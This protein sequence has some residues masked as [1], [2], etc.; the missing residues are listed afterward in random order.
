MMRYSSVAIALAAALI[1]VAGCSSQ[2]NVEQVAVA[3]ESGTNHQ[4]NS[5]SALSAA[6]IAPLAPSAVPGRGDALL[7]P[8]GANQA[9]VRTFQETP[10]LARPVGSDSEPG[11][12]RILNAKAAEFGNFSET[13]LDRIYAQLALLERNEDFSRIRVPTDA[14]PVVLTAIMDKSGKLKEIIVEQHSGKAIIDK[15]FI[16]AC[17]RGV[18]YRNPPVE[19]LSGNGDYRLRIEGKIEN[20]ASLDQTHWSFKTSVGIAIQ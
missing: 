6:P 16:D 8:S 7:H 1:T 20:F 4:V 3:P 17:K 9:A 5:L 2:S 18:W 14:R 19:A 11:E 10:G 12:E 13:L 15:L